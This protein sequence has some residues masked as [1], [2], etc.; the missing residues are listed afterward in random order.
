MEPKANSKSTNLMRATTD[1]KATA[2]LK[3]WPVLIL[4]MSK[5]AASLHTLSR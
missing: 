1:K 5:A 2:V 3:K 4:A